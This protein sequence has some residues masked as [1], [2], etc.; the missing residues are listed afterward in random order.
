MKILKIKN[1]HGYFLCS[2]TSAWK[3]IDEIDKDGLMDLLNQ[4]LNDDIEIEIDVFDEALI[5]NQAQRII[6]KSVFEKFLSLIDNKSKF[7]DE[8]ERLY[9]DSIQKYKV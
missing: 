2:K 9:L 5:K 6:Y 4:Y 3:Q 1:S 8:S 7:K